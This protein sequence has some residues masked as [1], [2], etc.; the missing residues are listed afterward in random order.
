MQLVSVVRTYGGT[1]ATFDE[2]QR[3]Y[4]MQWDVQ[5]GENDKEAAPFAILKRVLRD[6]AGQV[7]DIYQYPLDDPYARCKSLQLTQS[8]DI[9]T[10]WTL[11]AKCDTQ[12]ETAKDQKQQEKNPN[13]WPTE[14]SIELSQFTR[15]MEKDIKGK[16][17]AN[18]HGTPIAGGIEGDDSRPI[19]VCQKNFSSLNSVIGF[20]LHFKDAV[21]SKEFYGAKKGQA[22]IQ[23]ITAGKEMSENGYTYIPVT[24]KIAFKGDDDPD[25]PT[26]EH[27]VMNTGRVFFKEG[28]RDENGR[29]KLC[30]TDYDGN[31]VTEP[32]PLDNQGVLIKRKPNGALEKEPHYLKFKKYPERNFDQLGI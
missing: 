21:N 30:N 24:I 22:K 11:T 2:K 12:V 19:L 32:Q 23:S 16:P 14:Y 8:K 7:P 1:T 10:R 28:V 9:P 6:Y 5:L 27:N 13:A 31:E 25:G 20:M 3:S 15:L 29:L 18:T 17:V 4:D 26:W